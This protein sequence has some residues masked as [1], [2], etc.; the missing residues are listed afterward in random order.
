[1]TIR[2]RQAWY[3]WVYYNLSFRSVKRDIVRFWQRGM[4]GW[5]E[6]DVWDFDDYLSRIIVGGVS[7]LRRTKR[8][9]PGTLTIGRLGDED[10]PFSVARVRWDSILQKII[11]GFTARQMLARLEYYVN[12]IETGVPSLDH[13]LFL[14]LM[15]KSEEGMKLFVEHYD[16][17]WD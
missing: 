10:I 13:A 3:W 16:S 7:T 4:R 15:M 9:V 8:S 1:M 6:Q 2:T 14:K 11:E 17:L 12:D 5:S